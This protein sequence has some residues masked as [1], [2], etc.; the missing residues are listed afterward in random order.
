MTRRDPRQ[1]SAPANFGTPY[2]LLRYTYSGA[3]TTSVRDNDYSQW[4]SNSWNRR[5]GT[6]TPRTRSTEELAE[7]SG[8]R[9]FPGTSGQPELVAQENQHERRVRE[10]RE[11]SERF[12][13]A[14]R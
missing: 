9:Y 11:A 1:A 5:H 6:Q 2:R 14:R 4:V 7:N 10:W 13:R 12:R 3:D 8:R